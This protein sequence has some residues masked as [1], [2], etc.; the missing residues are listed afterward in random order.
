MKSIA[1]LLLILLLPIVGCTMQQNRSTKTSLELQA[2][3]AKEFETTKR[4]AF[5]AVLSVFQD[6]GYIVES[7]DLDTGFITA[8]SPT[9]SGLVLFVGNVMKSSKSTAFVEQL[10]DNRTKVRLN[11]VNNKETSSGYGAKRVTE[12]PIEDPATYENAFAKIQEAIFI[13]T[14]TK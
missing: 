4:I 11:F 6:L 13:R 5:P 14:E 7:A 3:Q 9:D 2:I 10:S 8:K 1:L 12:T